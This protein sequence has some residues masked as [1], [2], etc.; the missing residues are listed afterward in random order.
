[1]EIPKLEIASF[2]HLKKSRMKKSPI[3]ESPTALGLSLCVCLFASW[4]LAAQTLKVDV[5]LVNVFATVKDDRG[6]FITNLSKEDFRLYDDDQPQD[7]QIFEKQD[8]VD[9]AIGIVLDTSGS[10]VDIMPYMKRGVR[11]FVRVLPKSDDFFLV[12]F[13]TKVIQLHASTQSKKHL[14]DTLAGLRPFG[15]SMLF[16]GLLYSMQQVERSDHP[17]KALI[18]FTDGE[19]NGSTVSHSRVVQEAQQSA[20]LLYFVAIGSKVLIDEHTL[21]SLSDVSGGRTFYVPKGDAIAPIMQQIDT[22]L[23]QQYYLGYYVQRRP[24]SHRIRID[25]PGRDL[26]IRAKTGYV[27]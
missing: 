8:K 18:V 2:L 12:S 7:I 13:G 11:E 26:R 27:N 22:E 25:I 14:E 20:V 15:T 4:C 16:D 6:N 24:G 1:L 19:D 3:L 9:S 10:M 5:N 17:R 23:G 21:E